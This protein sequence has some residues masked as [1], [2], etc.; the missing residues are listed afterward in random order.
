MLSGA[1]SRTSQSLDGSPLPQCLDNNVYQMQFFSN[2]ILRSP[3]LE[4][5][6]LTVTDRSERVTNFTFVGFPSKEKKN[7]LWLECC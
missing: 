4:N 2:L 1:H 6:S 3:G 7:P 5:D